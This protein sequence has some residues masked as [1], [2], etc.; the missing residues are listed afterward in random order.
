MPRIPQ[1]VNDVEISGEWTQSLGV[2]A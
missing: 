2:P 1:S